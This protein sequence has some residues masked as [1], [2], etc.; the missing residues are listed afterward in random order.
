MLRDFDVSLL[1][2]FNAVVETGSVTAAARL[3][4]R[5]Q[6]AVSLQIKRLEDGLGQELFRR[7]HRRLTLTPAGEKLI[8]PATDLI[9][10]NDATWG[11]MTTPEFEGEVR[12]GVP[13]DIVPTYIPPILRRFN[14]AWPS[15]RVTLHAR[16]SHHLVVACEKG[17]I[18]LALTTDAVHDPQAEM[19]RADRLVWVAAPGSLVHRQ[20]P[21]PLA[22]GDPKCRFRPA[23][24]DALRRA[25][26]NWRIVLEVP[27]QIA[28]D[29]TVGAGIAVSA[30]LRDSVPNYL[31]VLGPAAGLPELPEFL[32]N[33]HHPQRGNAIVDEFA[34]HIRLEFAQRFGGEARPQTKPPPR[35]TATARGDR[36][37]RIAKPRAAPTRVRRA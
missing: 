20:S 2:A 31:Q 36:I 1:R 34:R 16:Y 7:E 30:S 15:V 23:V 11:Q 29:A 27:S 17:E 28:Q 26:R 12:F 37:A 8:G 6:A 10:L 5:T 33:L 22:V 32:I 19:L 25:G 35:K 21:L 4:N 14:A 24:F 9:A 18:D 3:L 13:G